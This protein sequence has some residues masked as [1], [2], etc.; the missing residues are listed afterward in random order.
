MEIL[1]VGDRDWR[2]VGVEKL[3]WLV[4]WRGRRW[5]LWDI[6]GFKVPLAP[7]YSSKQYSPF[8]K[9]FCLLPVSP[10][11]TLSRWPFL[12]YKED[13]HL[14]CV[15]VS[16][17]CLEMSLA[18]RM[19]FLPNGSYAFDSPVALLGL[20]SPLYLV[21]FPYSSR[22]LFFPPSPDSCIWWGKTNCFLF[23]RSLLPF[24]FPSP[25]SFKA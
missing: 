22:A 1:C 19:A 13:R 12:L 23:R 6:I 2:C 10:L 11:F 20:S 18:S 5:I 3:R 14:S 17:L 16:F 4:V 9:R 8:L 21:S 25:S 7:W 24:S 15:N